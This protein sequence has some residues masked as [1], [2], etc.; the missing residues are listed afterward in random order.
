MKDSDTLKSSDM[1]HRYAAIGLLW[2][3]CLFVWLGRYPN[4]LTALVFDQWK[5]ILTFVSLMIL[6][7][8][9]CRKFQWRVV[10]ICLIV[11]CV[12]F[13]IAILNSSTWL[14]I[15][16]QNNTSVPLT[17]VMKDLSDDR[18]RIVSVQPKQKKL[19]ELLESGGISDVMW[20]LLVYDK[21]GVVHLQQVIKGDQV[22]NE[23]RLNRH[24][25][26]INPQSPQNLG[27]DSSPSETE[28]E[29]PVVPPKHPN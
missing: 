7:F 22:V 9:L 18:L 27:N 29:K 6:A 12:L 23:Y 2:T 24:T 10:R 19:V 3:G 13:T 26:E 16:V 25:V 28:D 1:K 4:Q 21:D 11:V 14:T 5:L 15:Y 17:A 20:H 8:G